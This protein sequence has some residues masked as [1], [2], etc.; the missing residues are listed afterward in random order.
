[1]ETARAASSLRDEL[2]DMISRG[3]GVVSG[4]G[5]RGTGSASGRAAGDQ[6]ARR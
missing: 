6:A 4:A 5:M 3:A 2:S 1:M